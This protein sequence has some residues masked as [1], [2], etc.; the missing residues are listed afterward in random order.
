MDPAVRAVVD[1][2]PPPARDG[3]LA[4]RALILRVAAD[5]PQVG[6]I[7]EALRWGEPAYLTPDTRS[8]S[9]IRIGLPRSGGFA[10]YCNCQTSLI[11]DFRDQMGSAFRYE[12]NRAVLFRDPADID[13]DRLG[14]L[15]A[16]ALTWHSRKR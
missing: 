3:L 12:G 5:L 13:P 16:R 7:H 6:R 1:A 2:A 8:G 4:L 15:I 9:T 10:L 11:A 14:I